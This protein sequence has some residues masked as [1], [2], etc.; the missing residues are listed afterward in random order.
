MGVIAPHLTKLLED[1]PLFSWWYTDTRVADRDLRAIVYL[2]GRNT[3]PPSLRVELHCVRQKVEKNLFDLA[4]I[5]DVL[6]KP[7]VHVDIQGNAVLHGA[8]A[9]K[10]PCVV[11]RQGQI[12]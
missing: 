8:L 1:R 4:L 6:A 7:L 5:T 10:S 2:V 11:D 12:K 9:H 3:D